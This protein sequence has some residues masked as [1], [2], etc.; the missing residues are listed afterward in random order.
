MGIERHKLPVAVSM[1][2]GRKGTKKL[3][4]KYGDDLVIVRYRYDEDLGKRYTTVEIVESEA[5]WQPTPGTNLG[6]KPKHRPRDRGGVKI[7]FHETALREQV[8]QL[9]AIWRPRHRL[10]E[11]S[12]AQ[13]SALGLEDR[14][15]TAE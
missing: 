5:P 10:W 9:G 11:L 6:R 4:A 8:K 15:A 2:P 3:A 13:A 12:F 14:I 7:G 1:A